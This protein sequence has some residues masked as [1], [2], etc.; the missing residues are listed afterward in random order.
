MCPPIDFLMTANRLWPFMDFLL[1]PL[2]FGIFFAAVA[3][4][5]WRRNVTHFRQLAW[6]MFA[7][8][9][10]TT[11]YIAAALSANFFQTRTIAALAP[12]CFRRGSFWHSVQIAGEEF[13]F[14]THVI[15]RKYGVV[16]GWSFKELD[17]YPIPESVTINLDNVC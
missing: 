6:C 1:V 14:D 15:A 17:F 11:A 4:W 7:I 3:F 16:Y 2:L 10:F 13:Q 5:I 8:A 12:D 9:F